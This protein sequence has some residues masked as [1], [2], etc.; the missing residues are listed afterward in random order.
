MAD[1]APISEAEL[2]RRLSRAIATDGSVAPELRG[3]AGDHPFFVGL[4]RPEASGQARGKFT[5]PRQTDK[6]FAALKI[7][8]SDKG[9]REFV[10][11]RCKEDPVPPS[12]AL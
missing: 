5:L 9:P 2:H 11:V 12:E 6:K 8:A 3:M 4:L 10:K 7:V 1:A